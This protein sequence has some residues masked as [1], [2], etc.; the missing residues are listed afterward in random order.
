MVNLKFKN[1]LFFLSIAVFHTQLSA[2]T[3]DST[4]F[5]C[6]IE[7]SLT[8]G[9]LQQTIDQNTAIGEIVYTLSTNCTQTLYLDIPQ[10]NP[11]LFAGINAS[12][13]NNTLKISGTPTALTPGTYPFTVNIDNRTFDENG[14]VL[15]DATTVHTVN[16]SIEIVDN[17]I[18]DAD[19][20]GIPDESDQC[21]DTP[22]GEQVDQDGCGESQKDDDG[23]GV[24][25]SFDFCPDTPADTEVDSFGCATTTDGSGTSTSTT[26]SSTAADSD[27]DGI[28]DESDQCPDT[29]FGEQ[30]DQD[31]CGESQKDDDGDGVPNGF[32]FCPD[33]PADTQVDFFGCKDD[34]NTNTSTNTFSDSDFDGITDDLDACPDTPFGEQVDEFGCEASQKDEDGDGIIDTIDVCPNTP[35]GESVDNFGC[36]EAQTDGS[37]CRHN[38]QNLPENWEIGYLCLGETINEEI[39]ISTNCE[40][41]EISGEI[42]GLPEGFFTDIRKDETSGLTILSVYGITA[43][44]G[45]YDLVIRITD[46][47][48]EFES[49]TN[50]TMV[51]SSTCDDNTNAEEDSDGDGIADFFDFC[52]DTP[53][54]ATVDSFGCTTGDYTGTGSTTTNDI[55]FDGVEDDK[56]ECPYTPFGEEVDEKGCSYSQ[57]DDDQDGVANYFDFCPDTP[58][59]SEVD[60]FGCSTAEGSYTESSTVIYYDSDFDGITDDIDECPSTPYGQAVD[61]KG[62]SRSET[63]AEGITFVPDDA[64]EQALIDLGYDDVLDDVVITENIA[65]IDI[66]NLSE[67]TGGK[68]KDLMGIENF[69]ALRQLYAYNHEIYYI[70]ISRNQNLEVLSVG[71]NNLTFI[72]ISNNPSLQMLH[73]PNNNIYGIDISNNLALDDLDFSNNY[74]GY[75]DLS[76]HPLLVRLLLD[77]CGID[78][79]DVSAINNLQEFSILNNPVGCIRVTEEQLNNI[80]EGWQKGSEASYVIDCEYEQVS[81]DGDTDQDGVED[82]FDFCPDTPP[83]QIVDEFGCAIVDQ[84][85]DLDGIPDT[86]DNCPD[87]EAGSLVDVFGCAITETDSDF[88]GVPNSIDLCPD[89]LAGI[90]VDEFGCSAQQKEDLTNE[91]DDDQDGIINVLDRCPETPQGTVVN[92]TGCTNEEANQQQQL[93]EDFDGISD[94]EDLCP[95]TEIGVIVNEFGCPLNQQDQD[96]D[97]VTDDID[98][99][100]D[101]PIGA[102][103]NEFGCSVT[104]KENDSD[105]D[106]VSNDE[107]VCPKT[108]PYTSV[109]AKGCS[110]EQIAYDS[111][112]DGIPNTVDQCPNTGVNQD[113]DNKG[114]SSKQRDDDRDGVVNAIDRCEGTLYGDKVDA[115]GCSNAQIDGDDDEDGVLNSVDKCPNTAQGVDTDT[116]GCAFKAPI[117]Q[118]KSF[119]AEELSRDEE[120][121]QVNVFLGRIVVEDPNASVAGDISKISLQ[122]ANTQDHTFVELRSDS[123]FLIDRLDYE[124]KPELIFTIEATNDKNQTTTKE[125]NLKVVDIPNTTSLSNFEISVFNVENESA[126]AKVDYTRYL[127]PN[128]KI[129]GVGKWKIKKKIVGGA[130]RDKFQVKT[131]T[132]GIQGKDGY[133]S[134]EEDYLDF[135]TPPDFENPTDH[136]GDN[137]YEVE[138]ANIN[139]ND[140]ESSLPISVN[141]TNLLV[142]ENDPTTVQLQSVPASATDDTDG[143]GVPDILDNSPFVANPDQADSD[144]DGVGDVTD[145][146][147][148]D[149]VWNPADRCPNT[150]IDT[151]VNV[152]GCAIF[153]LPPSNF[154]VSTRQKCAGQN[155]INIG[156]QNTDYRYNISISGSLDSTST[157]QEDTWS[158]PNLSTGTYTL[159]VTVDGIDSNEFERCFTVQIEDPQPLSVYSKMASS[160]KSVHYTLS[161]G[162]VYT[163][164]H[165]GKSYQTRDKGVDIPLKEGINHIRISTGIECQGIYENDYFNSAEVLFSPNPFQSNLSIYFGGSDSEV[166]VEIYTTTGRLIQASSHQLSLSQRVIE[167]PTAHLKPGSYVVKSCG[168]TILQSELVIKN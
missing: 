58:A 151:K 161:G 22:F 162:D 92:A 60:A 155:A 31:G 51:V 40:G 114:C 107:D 82:I 50:F 153:Y 91:A 100:P 130:D 106:G 74:I 11:L 8:G 148:H 117:I 144:G 159:C 139:T 85:G 56:D 86:I 68:I 149:G 69:T 84:D 12:F 112:F 122:L 121:E 64:F 147:D 136:N 46:A 7:G 141:Q 125:I 25:N 33:T 140:G 41:S 157:F 55:D 78:Y 67:S 15:T 27:F 154:N 80:P 152:E 120:V 81:Y 29:P 96:F 34:G 75:L 137:I 88:D 44:P 119:E 71:N 48:N 150:P 113:V 10:N 102:E 38:I 13:E 89:S 94:E 53:A 63:S 158:M 5:N 134:E 47:P 95:G 35:E 164:T 20:D 30:V 1:F 9:S 123:L 32:D 168:E 43:F 98:L 160:G 66:L 65:G 118:T 39:T 77:N 90:A 79:I 42:T 145:D 133:N 101:T 72:D 116:N 126:G 108:P 128:S 143:D 2:S 167:L 131:R 129:K 52:P 18:A 6:T 115:Y 104:Q 59:E 156:V 142:P 105:M 111:D 4:A 45:S 87:T 61:E 36:S 3:F 70:D 54:G 73:I 97:K 26:S 28:P 76:N 49:I 166:T 124:A 93:D 37:E 14:D 103:V 24:P 19:F 163:I 16:G 99:C 135:I 17:S 57:L 110:D 132:V 127:N 21:P 138:V 62:C 165:N 23:D 109:D 83:S 146:A